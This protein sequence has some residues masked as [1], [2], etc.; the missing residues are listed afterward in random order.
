MK[1]KI[2][3][4]L[5][6]VAASFCVPPAAAAQRPKGNAGNGQV[7]KSLAEITAREYS[8]LESLLE[9]YRARDERVMADLAHFW[10]TLYV[11]YDDDIP[12]LIRRVPVSLGPLAQM[13]LTDLAL[14]AFHTG[15]TGI[16]NRHLQVVE[17]FL[18]WMFTLD[19]RADAHAR[20][21]RFANDWYRLI[22]DLRF[23]RVELEKLE[24]VL[25]RARARFP[26]D[27]DILV[28][29]GTYEEFELGRLYAVRRQAQ[30]GGKQ[31]RMPID[32]TARELRAND[33]YREAIK[34]D[35]QHAEARIRLAYLLMRMER[36]SHH[37]EALTLLKDARA[38]ETKPPL[39]Y[40]AALF[41]GMLEERREQF[42][43]AALWY[44]TAIADCPRAQT[45]RLS[46]SHLQLDH[47]DNMHVAQN[48]LRPL[49]GGPPPQDNAC[50]PD[51]WRIYPFGQAW[52]FD[53]L[54]EQM[55]KWVRE[56]VEKSAS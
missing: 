16:A 2:A 21:V 24:V 14:D 36:D 55:R 5:V 48:T 39:G 38:I 42:D 27:P 46:L 44:R 19:T 45:A 22:S 51:P 33:Y 56:P 30:S 3:L 29:S 1:S 12:R 7:V 26:I 35:P 47:D 54:L 43:A 53:D 50:E 4:S 15:D 13:A 34:A 37:D 49:I 28:N 40:L 17:Q 18:D 31:V 52:R 11:R 23:A 8:E 6:I 25:A 9:R 10:T 32:L 41:A 20:Q